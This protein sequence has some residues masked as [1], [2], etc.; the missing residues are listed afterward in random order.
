M[1][2]IDRFNSRL[3]CCTG[4]HSVCINTRRMGFQ[5]MKSVICCA[6]AGGQG[7]TTVSQLLHV[8]SLDA[9]N[10]LKVVSADFVDESGRSKIGRMYPGQVE[11]LG[12]GPDVELARVKNDLNASL[13]YWDRLGGL[14]LKG[15]FVFDMGANVIDQVLDWGKARHASELMRSRSAPQVEVVLV[16]RAEKRAIDDMGDLVARFGSLESLPINRIT[17]CKNEIAGSF[18]TLD[19]ESSLRRIPIKCELNFFDLPRCTSELWPAMEARYVGIG[20]AVN[21]TPE[22]AVDRLGVDVW[23]SYSGVEDLQEWYQALARSMKAQRLV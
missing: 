6:H 17:V 19:L 18:D 20:E 16:C 3:N 21:L 2:L 5:T 1:L 11:E 10:P 13:K 9:G 8:V 23:S 14:L 4:L 22:M 15:G 12:T 7:K